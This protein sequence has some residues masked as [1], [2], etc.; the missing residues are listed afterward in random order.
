MCTSLSNAWQKIT[1]RMAVKRPG[2]DGKK[3]KKRKQVSGITKT[4]ST[5]QHFNLKTSNHPG[6]EPL[7]GNLPA[8]S[9]LRHPEAQLL[10][11]F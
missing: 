5:K 2:K 11:D 6:R 9:S 1:D 7:N 3:K 8:G 4:N 10:S